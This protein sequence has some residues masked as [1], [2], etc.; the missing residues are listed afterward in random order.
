MALIDKLRAIG[1]GFRESRGTTQ[2]YTLD[3]MA[4]MAREA[5]GADG[6]EL[7]GLLGNTLTTLNNS[8]ATTIRSRACQGAT[9]LVSVALPNVTSMGTHAFYNCSGLVTVDMPK[10]TSIPSQ[11]FY[12]CTSLQRADFGVA[13][14]IAAQAFNADQVLTALILRRNDAICS[15]SNTSAISNT[16]I[17]KG[18]GYIY[19]PKSLVETYKT[20]TNWS[21]Y[22][23]QIRAIEDYPEIT[24]G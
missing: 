7:V 19:V 12:S 11:C 10:V 5:S 24:G 14:S 8:A 1:D 4:Q 15:L 9:K 21:T 17:G 22:E 16:S 2:E 3:E 20:A 18:T 13:Q 23:A 6:D